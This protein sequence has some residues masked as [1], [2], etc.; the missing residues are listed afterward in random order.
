MSVPRLQGAFSVECLNNVIFGVFVQ[1]GYDKP[2]DDQ[3]RAIKEFVQGRDVFVSLPTGAGK[4]LCYATLPYVFD[5]LRRYQRVMNKTDAR[6][7]SGDCT[8]NS[9]VIVVS[10]LLAL[11]SDQVAKFEQ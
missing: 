1:L 10:P 5:K 8:G 11:M 2:A 6:E 9:I 4:S 7:I 3:Q